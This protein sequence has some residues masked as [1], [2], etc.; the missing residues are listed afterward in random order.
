MRIMFLNQSPDPGKPERHAATERLL[1]SYASPGTTIQLCYPEDFPGARV[2]DV[3]GAQ[4]VLTGLHHA[5]ETPALVR[6]T[7]W[8]QE[9]GFDAVIQSNTF[10]P[11][12]E[13][14]R[15]AVRIPVI[16]LLRATMHT[17]TTLADRIGITVPLEGHVPLTW[18]ILRGYGLE[19][20]VADIRPIRIYGDDLQ[21]R[22]GEILETTV[23]VMHGLVADHRV[24]SIIPLGGALFP[25]VVDPRDLEARVGVPVLNT[26]AIGIRFAETCVSLGMSHSERTYP[27]ARIGYDDFGATAR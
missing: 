2:F 4:T 17:A 16:G 18:R 24:E 22:K 23:E 1:Q 13:A 14:A 21:A 6:K 5:M 3:M 27:T 12:V 10:D 19:R 25:Y 15:L 8:A 20:F 11:G 26:K 9:N 7:V